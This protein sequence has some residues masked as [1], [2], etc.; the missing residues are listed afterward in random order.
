MID[1]EDSYLKAENIYEKLRTLVKWSQ[2]IGKKVSLIK[3]DNHSMG[4]IETV[5]ELEN[6]GFIE[7]LS[8]DFLIEYGLD[9]LL[10]AFLK[11]YVKDK[12]KAFIFLKQAGI[13]D[14]EILYENQ[15][16][17]SQLILRIKEVISTDEFFSQTFEENIAISIGYS[18]TPTAKIHA[19]ILDLISKYQDSEFNLRLTDKTKIPYSEQRDILLHEMKRSLRIEVGIPISINIEKLGKIEGFDIDLM[20]NIFAYTYDIK[21]MPSSFFTDKIQII[22]TNKLVRDIEETSSKTISKHLTKKETIEPLQA[23]IGYNGLTLI[24]GK[25]S[26]PISGGTQ[27]DVLSLIFNSNEP[28][29]AWYYSEVIKSHDDFKKKNKFQLRNAMRRLNEKIQDKYSIQKLFLVTNEAVQVNPQH[30][31][32]T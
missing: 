21:D 24:V 14:F 12:E 4:Y 20:L 18:F 25:T 26:I 23:N 19:L 31:L 17:L 5:A 2:Q 28:L 22:P 16:S 27:R 29:E 9:P 1:M 15:Q 13:K 6:E 7:P 10:S 32:S 8:V 30:Q 3:T 11:L